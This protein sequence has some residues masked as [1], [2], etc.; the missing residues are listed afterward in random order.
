[1]TVV[2]V[3]KRGG[4]TRLSKLEGEVSAMCVSLQLPTGGSIWA[5]VR[6]GVCSELGVGMNRALQVKL[7]GTR[8]AVLYT[9]LPLTQPTGHLPES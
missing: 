3:Q 5:A 7:V 8:W 6:A 1:M 4:W 9:G 2:R